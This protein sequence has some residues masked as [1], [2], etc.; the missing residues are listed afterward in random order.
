MC[1]RAWFPEIVLQKIYMYVCMY[2]CLSFRTHESKCFKYES[3]LYTSN[4]GYI[5]FTH[6]TINPAIAKNTECSIVEVHTAIIDLKVCVS[7]YYGVPLQFVLLLA[8]RRLWL[9]FQTRNNVRSD[10]SST[11]LA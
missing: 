2:I 10:P 7:L 5:T 6:S 11:A 1:G 9:T 4:K 8:L 3:N